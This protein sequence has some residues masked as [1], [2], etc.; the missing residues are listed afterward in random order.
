MV[1]GVRFELS[2]S[3]CTNYLFFAVLGP[4]PAYL[5]A[6]AL[7]FFTVCRNARLSCN[8]R[9]HAS[10]SVRGSLGGYPSYL[11]GDLCIYRNVSWFFGAV[12][13]R[14]WT[15]RNTAG[16]CSDSSPCLFHVLP[17]SSS[18]CPPPQSFF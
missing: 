5:S 11:A 6:Y 8:L 4:V 12:P 7:Y 2:A 3:L 15:S 14:V 13:E 9:C 1:G 18:L 17:A 16:P 10:G